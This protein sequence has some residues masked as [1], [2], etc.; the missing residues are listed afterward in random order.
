MATPT[1]KNRIIDY[2]RT[3]PSRKPFLRTKLTDRLEKDDVRIHEWT[4]RNLAS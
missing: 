2:E 4:L 3:T 1:K